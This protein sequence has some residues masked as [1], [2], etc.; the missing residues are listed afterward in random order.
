MPK[1]QYFALVLVVDFLTWFAVDAFYAQAYA[2]SG[3][4][5]GDSTR[6]SLQKWKQERLIGIPLRKDYASY[7]VDQGEYRTIGKWTNIVYQ[8]LFNHN[9]KQMRNIWET[10]AGRKKIAR[11]NIPESIGLQAVA[12]CEK[13]VVSLDLEEVMES[14]QEAIALAKRKFKIE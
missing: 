7:L 9:A 5:Y 3:L 14:H 8:G 11:N 2:I 12:Y 6:R 1:I 13:L 10:Q 4:V